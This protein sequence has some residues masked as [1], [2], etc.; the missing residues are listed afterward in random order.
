MNNPNTRASSQ[1]AAYMHYV[2]D[3]GINLDRFVEQGGRLLGREEAEGLRGDLAMPQEKIAAVSKD[4]P[5][6]GRQ[7]GFLAN[8]IALNPKHLPDAA[9]NE[10]AFV[11]L[12]AVNENDMM[13]DSIPAVGYLDD[14]AIADVVFTRHAEILQRHCIAHSLDWAALKP[15]SSG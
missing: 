14:A 8:L 10:T 13:P 4:H 1:L 11:L 7:L 15:E 6:L 5:R 9:R 3:E 2:S 12:Y